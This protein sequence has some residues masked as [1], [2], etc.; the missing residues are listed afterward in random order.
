VFSPRPPL[1]SLVVL[2]DGNPP[3][4]PGSGEAVELLAGLL[5]HE[6][7]V[8]LRYSDAGPPPGA[9]RPSG[10]FEEFVPGWV[11]V[12]DAAPEPDHVRITWSPPSGDTVHHGGLSGN[13]AD[14]AAED[15]RT[16][17]YADLGPADA[18]RRRR[19]DAVVA[20]IADAVH[21]DLLITRRPYL[22]AV[23]WDL[24][25]K[26]LVATPEQALPMVSLYLR[27]QGAFITYR[28]ADGTA[29]SLMD[30]GLFFWTATRDLLPA[31]WR[32]LAA[33]AQHRGH[34][35]SLIYL[36]QSAFQRVQRA[37]QA[38]DMA[39]RALNRLQNNNTAEAALAQLDVVM[40]S[41]M[42]AADVL[43]RVA[44][45]VLGLVGGEYSAG[46]QRGR[47]TAQLDE[48]APELAELVSE[49]RDG[50]HVMTLLSK[51]RN[52]IHGAALDA[53]AVGSTT[54]RRESTL[55]GLPDGD[56]E[57]LVAAVE[58]L[59][60]PQR[61]G[62]AE[63]LPSRLHADPAV[64]LDALFVDAVRLLNKLMVATPVE[65]LEGVS[66]AEADLAP[67]T[68]EPFDERTRRSI[69]LQVGLV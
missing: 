65:R 62:I 37:L 22:H 63:V 41:L 27:T 60:G 13:A 54:A 59:G 18:A 29:T 8:R 34:D 39:L 38:R 7:V 67:P 23:G 28:S 32:W 6:S 45:R 46:W 61:F 68:H 20:M 57:E 64:L 16:D 36:A 51:L 69:R 66:L 25:R 50:R 3:G 11:L 21:A 48:A 4:D 40:L 43:A 53:L 33:C 58:A 2:V 12:H 10:S 30:E 49:G 1:R 5:S 9:E 14:V 26:V 42:A 24:P 19:D 47:W 17:A 35:E 15:D 52:S 55:V 31:G 56:V 44:H